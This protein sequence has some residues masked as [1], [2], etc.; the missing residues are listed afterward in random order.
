MPLGPK[1]PLNIPGGGATPGGSPGGRPPGTNPAAEFCMRA[2]AIVVDVGGGGTDNE[3]SEAHVDTANEDFELLATDRCGGGGGKPGP[4]VV[5]V[6]PKPPA[7]AWS[8]DAEDETGIW[9]PSGSCI[10]V[11]G[12]FVPAGG[13]KPVD[14]GCIPGS[15]DA[16]DAGD[17]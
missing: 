5:A 10:P 9:V 1:A 11:A 6:E 15:G 7:G 13:N 8:G 4:G 17:I 14:F 16:F 12:E 2:D 3:C